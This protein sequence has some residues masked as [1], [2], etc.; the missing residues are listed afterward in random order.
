MMFVN[1]DF[2][3]YRPTLW[4]RVRLFFTRAVVGVDMSDGTIVAVFAKEIDGKIIIV[5]IKEIPVDNHD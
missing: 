5:D 2:K 1:T 4:Q 3:T